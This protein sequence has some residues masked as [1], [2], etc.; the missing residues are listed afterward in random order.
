MHYVDLLY[1]DNRLLSTNR[2]VY[3]ASIQDPGTLLQNRRAFEKFL[4]EKKNTGCRGLYCV[5]ADANGLHE[6]NNRFGHAMGDRMLRA[7]ADLLRRHFPDANVYRT[8]GDEF[9]IFQTGT[10][11]DEIRIR[12]ETISTALAADGYSVSYGIASW[13]EAA[14]IDALVK[15]AD[16]RMLQ[17]K[18]LYYAGLTHR[19]PR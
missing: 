7:V 19:Q 8:G 1:P 18:E 12:L 9:V 14:D 5:Y 4:T 17:N 15:K 10:M 2:R 16:E 6:L 13:K 3:R 11:E